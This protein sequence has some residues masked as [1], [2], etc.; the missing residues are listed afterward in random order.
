MLIQKFTFRI[1]LP[2]L[3]GL[4]TFLNINAQMKSGYRAGINLTSMYISSNG[5]EISAETPVGIQFGG[6]YEIPLAK[7]FT[8][9]SGLVFTSKGTDYKI[10]GVN[11]SITPAYIEMPVHLVYYAGTGSFKVSIFAGPYLSSAFGGY[12]IDT[13]GFKDLTFGDSETKDLKLLDIG[14]DA[15]LG[16]NFNEYVFSFQYG[17]GLRNVSPREGLSM[18]NQVF[19]ISIGTLLLKKNK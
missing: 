1:L 4:F 18:K 12:K 19:G 15:G 9:Q 2:L 3:I 7:K 8:F 14:L 10:D 6:M 16:I 13:T 11:Y 5:N 17:I